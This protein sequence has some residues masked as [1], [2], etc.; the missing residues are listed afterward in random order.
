MQD[1]SRAATRR[2]IL[3]ALGSGALAW[4]AHALGRPHPARAAD[5]D[6]VQVG[7]EYVA[8]HVT[9]IHN[10]NTVPLSTPSFDAMSLESNVGT[11][12]VAKGST[13]VSATGS[14]TA[15]E[16]RSRN[17]TSGRGVAAFV[18]DSFPG[19]TPMA[20]AVY[21]RTSSDLAAIGV[22][23]RSDVGTGVQ[24]ESTRGTAVFGISDSERGVAG[25][26]SSSVGVHGETAG[27]STTS[28]STKAGVQ[29]R[30]SGVGTFGVYGVHDFAVGYGVY[31]KNEEND[32]YGY[33]GGAAGVAGA[34]PRGGYALRSRGRL[35]FSTSGLTSIPAGTSSRVIDVSFNIVSSSR[36][37]ATL[38]SDQPGLA[39]QRVVKD[40]TNDRFTVYLN[41]RVGSG[42]YARVAWLVLG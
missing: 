7:D 36:I 10:T 42:R 30:A 18:G 23:G 5:G 29:G 20:S 25:F 26:S 27:E 11:A 1:E 8:T 35:D 4:V 22:R 37:I 13:G 16:A 28:G 3:A 14:G 40:V 6:Y 39:I 15:I 12:L 24:G 21:G 32:N 9:K 31:G 34:S 2:S 17:R 41:V 33:I 38:E 19:E